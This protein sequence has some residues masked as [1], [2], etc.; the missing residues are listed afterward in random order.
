MVYYYTNNFQEIDEDE[1][2]G[3]TEILKE[4]LMT[5][6]ATFVVRKFTLEKTVI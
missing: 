3:I 1:Y 6:F 4:G 2:G 5:S